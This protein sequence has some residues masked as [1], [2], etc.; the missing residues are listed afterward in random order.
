MAEKCVKFIEE[1]KDK[2]FFIHCSAG[3]S[4]SQAFVKYI[5][6]VYYENDF[7]TNPDNPCLHP[8]GF[9]FQKLMHAYRT[10]P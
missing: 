5:K 1:N 3:I 4:R 7:Y 8:N 2:H 6:N 9:V 10:R